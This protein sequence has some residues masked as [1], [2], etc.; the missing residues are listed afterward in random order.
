MGNCVQEC[1][2]VVEVVPILVALYNDVVSGV[3]SGE[4]LQGVGV[5]PQS[6]STD[7]DAHRTAEARGQRQLPAQRASVPQSPF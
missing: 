1:I 4:G 7:H 3:C 5:G 6:L 2:E